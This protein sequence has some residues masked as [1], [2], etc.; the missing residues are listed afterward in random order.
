[1][2]GILGL[3]PTGDLSV[4]DWALDSLAHRGPDGR[5]VWRD[6]NRT[7]LGHRR[8][9]I[10]DT[11][12][13][14]SQPM[15]YLDRYTVVFNGEIY[16]FLEIR[17]ILE[18]SGHRFRSSSDTEVL[19]TSFVEWGPACLNRLNGMWAFAIWDSLEGRLF[20]SRDRLGKKPLFYFEEG[21]R[22]GFASE[23]KALLPFQA[24]PKPSSDFRD[25]CR[26]PYSYEVTEHCLFAGLKRFPPG[27]YAWLSE[28]GMEI[29]RYWA[30]NPQN[31]DIPSKYDDQVEVLRSLLQ[32][33]CN[34]R[35]RSDV[36]IGTGLSGGVDSSAV[37]ASVARQGRSGKVDRLPG[38]WQNA[39]TATFPETVMDEVVHARSVANHLGIRLHEV[40][41][42]PERYVDALEDWIFLF[43][44][45]HEVNPLPHIILYREMRDHG[46]I[47]SL[48]GHGGDELFCG[49]ESSVLHALPEALKNPSEDSGNLEDL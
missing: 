32:E 43:E 30:P 8:L 40:P 36:P 48:D 15:R 14:A 12:D 28:K 39:F 1:M 27:H 49:Y 26:N 18:Q 7:I 19:L 29:T 33:S 17:R 3:V 21:G 10:L 11:R 47:V 2:C 44:E 6:N 4:F 35:M 22:F 41:I 31:A 37:A 20:L 9:A 13:I 16:N 25:L 42:R 24:D 38:D 45:V 34:L 5:G 23:Q 46:V